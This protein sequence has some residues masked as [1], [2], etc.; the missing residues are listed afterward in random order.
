[1]IHRPLLRLTEA[2]PVLV[3]YED[4]RPEHRPI[5]DILQA[6]ADYGLFPGS[7][8]LVLIS[9]GLR[10]SHTFLPPMYWQI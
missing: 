8:G 1:M 3:C 7:T 4:G 6:P 5:C 9:V 10:T 2:W